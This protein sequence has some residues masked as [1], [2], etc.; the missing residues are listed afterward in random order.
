VVALSDAEGGRTK[1]IWSA[2]H[3]TA[4]A[5][6]AHLDMGYEQGWNAAADQLDALAQSLVAK[7]EN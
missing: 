2:R 5:R 3:A 4:E 6:Q 1:M 7:A